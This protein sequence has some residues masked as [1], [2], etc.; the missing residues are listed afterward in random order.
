MKV[1]DELISRMDGAQSLSGFMKSQTSLPKSEQ[2]FNKEENLKIFITATPAK[3][4]LVLGY[5]YFPLLQNFISKHFDVGKN[6][7]NFYTPIV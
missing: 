5:N 7:Q 4:L 3:K 6:I 1:C 2:F